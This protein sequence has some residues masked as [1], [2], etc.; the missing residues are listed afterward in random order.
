M[1]TWY[2]CKVK[3]N[4]EGED[5]IMKQVTEAFLVDSVT[6]TDAETRINEIAE[7]DIHGE[8]QVTNITKTNIGEVIPDEEHFTWFKC[9]VVYVTVDADSEKEMKINT[10]LLVAAEHIKQAFEK[11]ESHFQGTMIPYEVPSITRTQIVEVYPY[12]A[13]EIPANFKPISELE[14]A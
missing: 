14:K 13:D 8:F 1:K 2:S 12:V 9:K 7:R 6:Y 5:G 11:I 10:Y 4:K 3:S